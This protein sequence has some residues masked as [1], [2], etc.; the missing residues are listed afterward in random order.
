[1][2]MF[3]SIAYYALTARGLDLAQE[4]AAEMGGTIHALRRHTENSGALPFD[5]LPEL[6]ASTFSR[7]EAHVFVAA[8]GIVVR[9]IAPH[10]GDK[11]I[12]PAVVSLDQEGTFAVSLL[13]GH[14]GGANELAEKCAQITGG[15]AV[16]TTATDS[17]G[18]PSIDMVAAECDM[19][20]G[21][22][23]RIKTVNGALLD[24][25]T[26]QI[27]DLGDHLGLSGDARFV[28][29]NSSD[30]W[31]DGEPGV[32]VSVSD[33]CPDAEALWVFP[34]VLMLGVGCRLGV[35]SEEILSHI[36][37]V[38]DERGL[39]LAAV[40]G[41]G[42]VEA[43]RGEPGLLKAAEALGVK[44]TFYSTEALEKVSVPNPSGAVF[45]RMG[46]SSVSEAAALLLSE[47]GE[48]L[49]EKTKTQTVTL[50]VARR[51]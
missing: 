42:S 5:S 46:V 43:K 47:G 30:D 7:Y 41:L 48:L 14:L 6:V 32:W 31:Q 36:R 44:P 50:A 35:E 40:G 16:I 28:P 8:A 12:D 27:F 33:D 49:V 34:R 2:T 25:R 19:S 15:R 17:A 13:S 18:L 39:S 38:F 20:I 37:A 23:E 3:K 1:M 4:L 24:N 21:N 51:K 29:V 11:T 45:S 10:L 9:C 22:P 26:V